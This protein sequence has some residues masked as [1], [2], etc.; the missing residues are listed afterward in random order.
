MKMIASSTFVLLLLSVNIVQ[1]NPLLETSKGSATRWKRDGFFTELN[2]PLQSMRRSFQGLTS[3]VGRTM[4]SFMTAISAGMKNM[5]GGYRQPK[6]IHYSPPEYSFQ[7]PSYPLKEE[8]SFYPL[9]EEVKVS[10]YPQEEKEYGA[11]K[12]PPLYI[13]QVHPEPVYTKPVHSTHGPGCDCSDEGPF[14]PVSSNHIEEYGSPSAS[15]IGQSDQYGSP[16]AGPIGQSDQYGSPAAAPIGQTDQY[17][18]PAAGS[19]GQ[20]DQYGSPAAGP[21]GQSDQYG[22][23]SASPIGQSDQYGSPAGGPIGQTDQYGSPV[24]SPIGSYEAPTGQSADDYGSPIGQPVA[25]YPSPAGQ[26]VYPS[27]DDEYGTP[28]GQPSGQYVQPSQTVQPLQTGYVPSQPDVGNIDSVHL[29][30]EEI[31]A[32]LKAYKEDIH[33]A[34]VEHPGGFKVDIHKLETVGVHTLTQQSSAVV[35]DQ[36]NPAKYLSV[37]CNNIKKV[38]NQRLWYK[39]TRPLKDHLKGHQKVRETVKRFRV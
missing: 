16:A 23:P 2:D 22:S 19:I 14:L 38:V 8:G 6:V 17:G 3:N 34:P 25:V 15:P 9:E 30:D 4:Q 28:L 32:H 36:T 21:V 39:D 5:V 20:S 27:Q 29:T 37:D 31:C 33:S 1:A 13:N 35:P 7:G 26:A 24:T 12:Q 11:P 10:F 18:S